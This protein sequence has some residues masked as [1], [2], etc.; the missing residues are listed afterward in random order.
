MIGQFY[1]PYSTV[2]PAKFESSPS[3]SLT[4]K[5]LEATLKTSAFGQ[6]ISR[7]KS[8]K[9]KGLTN[10]KLDFSDLL[11]TESVPDVA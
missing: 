3:K 8:E 9:K 4:K 5:I 6:N 1:G 11:E 2:R 7:N 10:F